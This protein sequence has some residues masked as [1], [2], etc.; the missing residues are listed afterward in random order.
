[1]ER[2]KKFASGYLDRSGFAV[3]LSMGFRPGERHPL[4]LENISARI[5]NVVK[6]IVLRS[7]VGGVDGES[8]TGHGGMG[9]FG[10]KNREFLFADEWLLNGKY[11]F[12]ANNL[13][14]IPSFQLLE[15]SSKPTF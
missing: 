1:M 13:Q 9:A 4:T 3:G 7:T 11:I 15:T 2:E 5:K 8:K 14:S 12:Y 6:C 10:K